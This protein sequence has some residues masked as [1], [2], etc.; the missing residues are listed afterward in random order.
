MQHETQVACLVDDVVRPRVEQDRAWTGSVRVLRPAVSAQPPD[1][2][3][4]S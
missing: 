2:A 1:R 4:R 3:D